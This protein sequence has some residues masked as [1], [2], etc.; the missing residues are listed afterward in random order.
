MTD[1][2]W[3]EGSDPQAMLSLLGYWPSRGWP[4]IRVPCHSLAT[5]RKLRL[6]ACACCRAAWDELEPSTRRQVQLIERYADGEIT[7]FPIAD[8]TD[9]VTAQISYWPSAWNAA[10][11]T[12]RGLLAPDSSIRVNGLTQA[13][14]L[15]D[16]FG[17]LGRPSPWHGTLCLFCCGK[18]RRRSSLGPH[19]HYVTCDRC[20]GSKVD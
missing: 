11:L 19:W 17:E 5:D 7:T 2:Q 20:S 8:A 9:D 14:L 10:R 1:S 4:S 15:R 16:L 3:L 13:N 18:G 6:F 12:S